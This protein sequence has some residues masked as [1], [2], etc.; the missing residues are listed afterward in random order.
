MRR[1]GSAAVLARCEPS[2]RHFLRG[3]GYEDGI[4]RNGE[5][6]T[7]AATMFTVGNDAG[8]KRHF[9]LRDS[10]RVDLPVLGI[11]AGSDFPNVGHVDRS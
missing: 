7:A 9:M 3:K 6:P 10:Q 1:V 11:F 2:R 8:E 5:R 4:R